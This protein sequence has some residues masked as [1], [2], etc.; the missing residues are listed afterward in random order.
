ML[1]PLGPEILVAL[2][3][4][5]GGQVL[6]LP[7][8][9]MERGERPHETALRETREETG[10]RGALIAPLEEIAYH[11]HSR[12]WGTRVS[13]RVAFFLMAYRSGS[14]AHHD[15]EVEAVR[16]V[17]LHEAERRLAYPGERRVM[18]AALAH[19]GGARA[20]GQAGHSRARE[21]LSSR[22]PASPPE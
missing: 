3:V 15:D 11:Y 21:N 6:A 13:K 5:R 18:A 12:E 10:L 20:V 9:R 17:P 16:L 7:K 4:I 14:P 19:L 8:G 22:P 1:V 2:T